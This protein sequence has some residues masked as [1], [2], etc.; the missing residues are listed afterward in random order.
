MPDSSHEGGSI[1]MKPTRWTGMVSLPLM[2]L[3]V[4]GGCIGDSDQA[5][6][7]PPVGNPPGGPPSAKSSPK[8]REIMV[9]LTKG[10]N[11]LTPVIGKELNE[12]QPPWETLQPQTREYAQL[13]SEMGQYDPPRGSKESWAKQ[14]L[15]YAEMATEMDRATQARDKDAALA[16][17]TQIANSCNS[18]HREH[19]MMGPGRGGP[20]GGRPG[21]GPPPGGPGGPGFGPPPGG[22]GGPGGP[23]PGGPGGP[24]LEGPGGPPPGGPGGPPP[25]GPGGPPPGGPGGGV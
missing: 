1:T 19:R 15:A 23:P 16:V 18:C 17:H 20:P 25:G 24:P 21:F 14:T 22:P 5:Q 11:S 2:G 10:P 9:R 6:S 13:A 7:P 4:L 12:A 3:L 8:V